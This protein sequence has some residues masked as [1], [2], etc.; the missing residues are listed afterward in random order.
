MFHGKFRLLFISLLI[1]SA[2]A[3]PFSVGALALSSGEEALLSAESEDSSLA[4]PESYASATDTVVGSPT[5]TM[6]NSSNGDSFFDSS[7]VEASNSSIILKDGSS[8]NLVV[9]IGEL[10]ALI[11][12]G[13]SFDLPVLVATEGLQLYHLAFVITFNDKALTAI[14]AGTDLT[15]EGAFV[16]FNNNPGSQKSYT[17]VL[18]SSHG[19]SSPRFDQ[20]IELFYIHFE[21]P[22]DKDAVAAVDGEYSGS[23]SGPASIDGAL[24]FSIRITGLS[25]IPVGLSDDKLLEDSYKTELADDKADAFSPDTEEAPAGHIHT[26][27]TEDGA[28]DPFKGDPREATC[29]DDEGT[30]YTC[31]LCDDVYSETQA[32]TAINPEGGHTFTKQGDFVTRLNEPA[33]LPYSAQFFCS[34][35]SDKNTYVVKFV[36]D[37]PDGQQPTER[38]TFSDSSYHP[39]DDT[40]IAYYTCDVCGLKFADS[41]KTSASDILSDTDI[42]AGVSHVGVSFVPKKDISYDASKA[43]AERWDKQGNIDHWYCPHCDSYFAADPNSSDFDEDDPSLTYGEGEAGKAK[44][45]YTRMPGDVTGDGRVNTSDVARIKRYLGHDKSP[46]EYAANWTITVG[47]TSGIS[48]ESDANGDVTGDGRVNTSDVARIK[49]YLG[50]EKSPDEYATNWELS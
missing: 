40:Y 28:L 43:T 11:T 32:G 36:D 38:H 15:S 47:T 9:T 35:C 20:P 39:A 17:G 30:Y 3:L 50:H 25:V 44:V 37:T 22:N 7:A 31:T 2:L 10:P 13:S 46:D 33:C 1:I 24:D 23:Y 16:T 26:Y 42:L 41:S 29:T 6:D 18:A 5:D 34:V 14:S 8:G 4:V 19:L 21:M 45:Y 12:P 48:V 27:L 49:R